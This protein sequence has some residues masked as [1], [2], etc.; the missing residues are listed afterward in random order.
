MLPACRISRLAVFTRRK[1]TFSPKP[2]ELV[3]DIKPTVWTEFSTL[4]AQNQACNLG[5]GYADS[6]SPKILVEALKN[7]PNDSL[8]HQYTRGFGHAQLVTILAK[9]Y[10]ELYGV[11]IN[12]LDDV[13]VT[14]GAYLALYYSILGWV[15]KGDEVLIMDPAYD[16]YQPQVKMAGGTPIIIPMNIPKNAKSSS[17]FY[18]D[19][20]ELESKIT[21]KTKMLILNNP[22]NPTGK[23]WSRNELEKLAKI[24]KKHN[25][26]VIADEVYEFH[27]YEK[28]EMI[29][30]ASLPEMWQ[31]TISIG[32]AGKAFSATGWKLGWVIGPKNLLAPLKQLHQNC[33]H[34]CATPLQKAVADAFEKDWPNF[35]SNPQQSFLA[36]GLSGELKKKRDSLAKSLEAAN[37]KPILPQAGYFMLADFSEH[38]ANFEKGKSGEKKMH[39]I[40]SFRDGFVKRRNWL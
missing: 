10:G 37:F 21:N 15:N 32:S 25:L 35:Y 18:I 13:M 31:R 30:F 5:V 9:M 38:L 14:I 36:T 33:I 19:F 27:V 40:L 4:A 34:V 6:P 20:D 2:S 3:K 26:L 17:E 28:E 23:L 8:N 7:L 24:V 22:N 11:K 12:A 29:R 16:C 39:G 1:S